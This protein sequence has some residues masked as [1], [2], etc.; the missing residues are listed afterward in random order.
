M[1][2]LQII[3]AT[4]LFVFG[5]YIIQLLSSGDISKYIHPRFLLGLQLSCGV[6]LILGLVQ[7]WQVYRTGHHHHPNLKREA[8]ICAILA[9]P[10]IC[11]VFNPTAVLGSYMIEKKDSNPARSIP[12]SSSPANQE[13]SWEPVINDNQFL[14][15]MMILYGSPT[16]YLNRDIEFTAF[17]YHQDNFPSDCFLAA[18]FG[19]TCCAADAQVTGLLCHFQNQEKLPQDQWVRVKGM[20]HV[21]SFMSSEVPIVEVSS[22]Q[23]IEPPKNPY[24]Y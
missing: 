10:L 19:I 4:I 2:S 20:L 17:I 24:V 21:Q 11:G 15:A 6:F 3:R 23:L 7:L 12:V 9:F 18:R 14:A 5:Y 8:L 16:D 1:K 13:D 22:L